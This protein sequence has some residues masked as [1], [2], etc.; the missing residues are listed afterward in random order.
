[1]LTITF[2]ETFYNAGNRDS[3]PKINH[4]FTTEQQKI[5]HNFTTEQQKKDER[6]LSIQNRETLMS[7]TMKRRPIFSVYFHTSLPS[8]S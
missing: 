8:V 5:N 2:C 3:K 4:N 7:R 1:M 6:P